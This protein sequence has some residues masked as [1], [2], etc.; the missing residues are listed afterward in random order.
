MVIA[1][2]I[3][4]DLHDFK[5]CMIFEIHMISYNYSIRAVIII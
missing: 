5:I 3:K 1:R 2:K 4:L